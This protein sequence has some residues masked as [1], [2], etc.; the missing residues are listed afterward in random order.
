METT[1][2]STG[3]YWILFLL[4][5]AGLAVTYVYAGGYASLV[6][7]FNFTFIAKALDLM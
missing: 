3:I 5:I 1:K 7:P 6:L 4:S 2:K